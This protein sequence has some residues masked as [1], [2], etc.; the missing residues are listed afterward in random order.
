MQYQLENGSLTVQLSGRIGSDNAAEFERELFALIEDNQAESVI[1][2]AAG[3]EY[4]SS[5]GLR[6]ILKLK[7]KTADSK[8]INVSSEVYEIFQVTG[9]SEIIE[10]QKAFREISV[11]GCEVIG[12]G[13]FGIV[14]RLDADTIV[15]IYKSAGLERI[16]KEISYAKQAFQKGIPTAISFDIVKCNGRYGVVM[17]ML[18]S[19]MLANRIVS[20]PEKFDEYLQKYADLVRLVHSTDFSDI[21]CPQINDI[22]R[23]VL[24]K[25][26]GRLTETEWETLKQ[27][28]DSVPRRQTMIHGDLHTKNIMLQ[29]GELLLID[30]DEIMRGHPIYDIANIYFAYTHL[31]KQGKAERYVGLDNALC[32]K[33]LDRFM[34]LYFKDLSESD[35][36]TA[37]KGVEAFAL[38][39]GAYAVLLASNGKADPEPLYQHALLLLREGVLQNAKVI[40][41]A[42]TVM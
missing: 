33:V 9:F 39:R 21:D 11:E 7:K 2:D 4:I 12:E 10:V 41:E 42:L 8:V 30:M 35:F 25:I 18:K 29:D 17:E 24:G 31:I 40:A 16:R 1:L 15:K 26:Q 32:G 19:D 38:L 23:E 13:G 37:L 3:L 27:I 36:E 14:Y 34:K 28:L 20:E 22:Y 5:A 6:V